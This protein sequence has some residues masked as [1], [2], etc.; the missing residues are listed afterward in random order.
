MATVYVVCGFLA[1]LLVVGV[2]LKVS[3][4][5]GEMALLV[6]L[7]EDWAYR[8]P[9]RLRN[10]R[11]RGMSRACYQLLVILYYLVKSVFL[12]ELC[13]LYY[14]LS[15]LIFTVKWMWISGHTEKSI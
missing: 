5:T 13:L 7:K 1:V 2:A 14:I 10:N 3:V 4:E 9:Y 6:E 12:L 8:L 11:Y 15:G